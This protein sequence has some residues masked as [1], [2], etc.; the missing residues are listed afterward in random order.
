MS[1]TTSFEI[2]RFRNHSG[3]LSWR[4]CGWLAGVRVRRNFKTREE[5]AA[6]KQTLEIQAIQVAAGFRVATTSLTDAQH[7]TAEDA[8]RRLDGRPHSVLFY[9]KYALTNYREP[10]REKPLSEAVAEYLTTKVREVE[11]TLISSVQVQSIKN[12]L[13]H[14]QVYFPCG[15]VSQLTTANLTSY[16]ERG[17]PGL[18][19]YNMFVAKFRSMGEAALQAGNSESIIRKH[20]LDLK[21]SLQFLHAING[22]CSSHN[23]LAAFSSLP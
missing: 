16:L 17:S 10:S 14:L 15:P 22:F 23:L 11:R 20:Y 18:K 6:E 7:R 5:A 9:L 3:A 2:I 13:K 19:T 21:N 1:T 4:L 12:E 8:L